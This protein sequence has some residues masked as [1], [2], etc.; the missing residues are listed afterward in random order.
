MLILSFRAAALP[1]NHLLNLLLNIQHILVRYVWGSEQAHAHFEDGFRNSIYI[2]RNSL[3]HG[4][5]VHWFPNR[6]SLHT[7]SI[8]NHTQSLHVIIQ[9]AIRHY[10]ICHMNHTCSTSYSTFHNRLV[11]ILLPHNPHIRIQ[12]TRAQPVVRI[13]AHSSRLRMQVHT[14][15]IHQKLF[16]HLPDMLVVRQVLVNHRH[17]PTADTS[18]DIAQALVIADI[19]VPGVRIALASL[20]RIPHEYPPHRLVQA[21]QCTS[22]GGRNHLVP[23]ELEHPE[24]AEDAQ[25]LPLVPGPESLGHILQFTSL[26]LKTI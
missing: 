3:L 7:S 25:H 16:V 1:Y 19:L 24:L 2:R 4:L 6:T 21:D 22:A 10:G 13:I 11:G 23:I 26:R 18:A 5:F 9:M 15:D 20:R 8:P 14:R 12:S 17:Q